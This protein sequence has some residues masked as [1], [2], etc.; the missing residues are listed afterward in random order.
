MDRSEEWEISEADF[1]DEICSESDLDGLIIDEDEVEAD[2]FSA[3]DMELGGID[4]EEVD[5]E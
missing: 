4:W 3:L 2:E 5:E 1:E